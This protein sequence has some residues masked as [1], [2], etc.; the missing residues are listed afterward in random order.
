LPVGAQIVDESAALLT[1]RRAPWVICV[2]VV[3]HEERVR[4][5]DTALRVDPYVVGTVQQLALIAVDEDRDAAVGGDAPKL[6]VHV[7]SRD[8]VRLFVER[9]AIASAGRREEL[10]E[11][12]GLPFPPMDSVVGLVGEVDIAPVV[13]GRALGGAEAA[14]EQNRL[15]AL[16]NEP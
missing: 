10:S 9:H 3:A 14:T 4:E 11:L 6:P 15:G 13:G 1:A 16:R 8:Q 7:R 12:A 5:V 2:P